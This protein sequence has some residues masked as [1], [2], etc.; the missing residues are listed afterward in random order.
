MV[1]SD[2]G[3][4]HGWRHPPGRA[5]C[6]KS[7]HQHAPTLGVAK[8]ALESPSHHLARELDPRSIRVE[9]VEA[10]PVRTLAARSIPGFGASEDAWAGRAP[11]GGTVSAPAP[12]P[13]AAGV[14]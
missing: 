1:T 4:G 3:V 14:R 9:L 12:G 11:P 5:G 8:V 2:A 13:A 7:S 10:G 6:A